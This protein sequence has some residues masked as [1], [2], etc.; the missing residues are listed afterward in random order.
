MTL[1]PDYV[2]PGCVNPV[3]AQGEPCGDCRTA[4]GP[5]LRETDGP[6][7]TAQD[8]AERDRYVRTAYALQCEVAW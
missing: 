4:F 7:L 3:A 5:I 1:F 2:I 8:I 6:S